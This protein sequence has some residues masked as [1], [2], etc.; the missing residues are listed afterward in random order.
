MIIVFA[1]IFP[2]LYEEMSPNSMNGSVEW[3]TGHTVLKHYS[4]PSKYN[5]ELLCV[6]FNVNYLIYCVTHSI[7]LGVSNLKRRKKCPVV[8]PWLLGSARYHYLTSASLCF[9]KLHL[10]AAATAIEIMS[11]FQWAL[12]KLSHCTVKTF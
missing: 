7:H 9:P 2:T 4:F 8:F 5:T 3:K 11:L 10:Y 6:R 12:S 1:S